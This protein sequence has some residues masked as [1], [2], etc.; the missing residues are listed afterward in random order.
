MSIQNN[1]LQLD[2][3]AFIEF[4]GADHHFFRDLFDALQ[5]KETA[6]SSDGLVRYY[7]QA[8]I[9]FAVNSRPGSF[10][11]RFANE[12]G[13]SISG[14][15]FRVA[16]PGSAF[17]SAV[18][19]GAESLEIGVGEKLLD[20]PVLKGI[21]GSALYLVGADETLD[22]ADGPVSGA[23]FLDIDHLTHNVHRGQMA[24]WEQFY[25][26]V[27]G[28]STVFEWDGQ[29][30]ATG[31]QTVAVMSPC[32]RFRIAINE[33]TEQKSQIQ[34][35]IDLY[36][37][38]G[39]QHVA[40]SS[41]DL[42]ASLE[43]L[44]GADIPFQ[45]VPDTYY[46]SIEAR[47]PGHGEDVPRMKRLGILIDG[48]NAG[49]PDHPDWQLLLQIFSKN[50]IGPIFFEFIQRKGNAGF[51]EGNAKALFESI[52]REQIERGYVSESA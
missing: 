25:R 6:R 2:G 22:D 43:A 37:G 15:G 9:L 34:E 32:G 24:R 3:I 41:G 12:H 5:L 39:V 51:G 7:R 44:Q 13:P 45:A 49:T 20:V 50:Q 27:F 14:L 19:R 33:P 48:D 30:A 10:A 28:F 47:L 11:M 35:F 1:P 38:E 31:M 23:G 40:L 4:S 18:A 46:E 36:R 52:E 17:D 29:G 42:Y 21:G 8:D 26:Q 16:D